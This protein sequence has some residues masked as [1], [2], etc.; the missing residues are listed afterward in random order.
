V[1]SDSDLIALS[2]R[3]RLSWILHQPAGMRAAKFFAIGMGIAVVV[4]GLGI[5]TAVLEVQDNG[6]QETKEWLIRT[7]PVGIAVYLL[8][9]LIAFREGFNDSALRVI[10]ATAGLPKSALENVG[11]GIAIACF[12]AGGLM[13]VTTPQPW[14][15]T[16]ALVLVGLVIGVVAGTVL[17]WLG[18]LDRR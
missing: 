13:M 17:T 1:D 7:S 3:Q 9:F 18:R 8:P 4:T 5:W 6:W 16:V 11:R 14:P 12:V 15:A 2:L 10:R